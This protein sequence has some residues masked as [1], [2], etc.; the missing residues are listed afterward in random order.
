MNLDYMDNLVDTNKYYL[1]Y[2]GKI[3]S[4]IDPPEKKIKVFVIDFSKST[5]NNQLFKMWCYGSTITPKLSLISDKDDTGQNIVYSKK[6]LENRKFKLS[7]IKKAIK[8]ITDENMNGK[9]NML[10]TDL[11]N[12]TK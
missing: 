1:Y 11:L 9:M 3:K 10:I 7:D 6:E 5:N 12:L 2:K 8:L 4:E